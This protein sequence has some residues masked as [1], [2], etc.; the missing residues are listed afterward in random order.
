MVSFAVKG[1][2]CAYIYHGVQFWHAIMKLAIS[3][4]TKN[5]MGTKDCTTK[6]GAIGI[7]LLV[8]SQVYKIN[9][10]GLFYSKFVQVIHLQCKKFYYL[11]PM[12]PSRSMGGA[13]ISIKLINCFPICVCMH[14]CMCTVLGQLTIESLGQLTMQLATLVWECQFPSLTPVNVIRRWGTVRG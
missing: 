13:F 2:N 14:A 9:I 12:G 8:A 3:L 4:C 7:L 6:E 1:S 5:C 11:D 10:F